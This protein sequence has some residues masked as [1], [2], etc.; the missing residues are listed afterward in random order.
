MQ[1]RNI[2]GLYKEINA[3]EKYSGSVQR[4]NNYINEDGYSSKSKY[5][6]YGGG[7]PY[8]FDNGIISKSDYFYNGGLLNKDE[9]SLSVVGNSSYLITGTPY[10]TMTNAE[11]GNRYA[12]GRYNLS[13]EGLNSQLDTRVTEYVKPTVKTKG[14]GTYSDPWY[15]VAGYNVRITTNNIEYGY[16]GKDESGKEVITFEKMVDAGANIEVPIILNKGYKLFISKTCALG[17]DHLNLLIS[18]F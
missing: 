2:V 6:I 4:A 13:I 10:W 17:F 3:T 7:T 16:F 11:N 15:F 14:S 8:K 5:L 9:L 12:V 1:Q 18:I